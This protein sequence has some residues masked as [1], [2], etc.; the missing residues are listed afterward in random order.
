MRTILLKLDNGKAFNF[1]WPVAAGWL[2][3]GIVEPLLEVW[4]PDDLSDFSLVSH[5]LFC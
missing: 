2:L 1:D 5:L 3:A 4:Q